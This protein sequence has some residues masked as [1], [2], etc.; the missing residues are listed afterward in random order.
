MQIWRI[1]QRHVNPDAWVMILG[2]N[3]ILIS[4]LKLKQANLK[5]HTI[6]LSI[7]YH[8]ITFCVK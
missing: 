1:T 7:I 2:T 6:F 3:F 5:L 8:L 4:E